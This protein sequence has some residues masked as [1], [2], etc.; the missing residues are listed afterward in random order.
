MNE[1]QIESEPAGTLLD[2]I[3]RAHKIVDL[4]V[5]IAP[6]LPCFADS[7]QHF[8][9]YRLHSYDEPPW[10]YVNWLLL[11]D[12]H[13]GTH[14]DAPPHFIPPLETGLPHAAPAG[15]VTLEQ[16]PLEAFLGPAAV[17]DCRDLLGTAGPD[18]S[19]VILPDKIKEWEAHHGGLQPGDVV[20]L[21][22]SWSDQYFK[23]FP[24][25]YRFNR[26]HPAPG[27]RTIEY[28]YSKGVR[29]LGLDTYGIGLLQDDAA[30][31][32]AS[33]GK[34]MV[35]TEK[36]CN[37][38]QLPARGAYFLFLPIKVEG[39]TGGPGRAIAIV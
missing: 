20:L 14:C 17:V 9:K 29:H 21:Y 7:G 26:S 22:T 23:R 39:V 24:E 19:P 3:I 16:M 8:V 35:V 12:D 13:T 11:M 31:H 2:K 34:G 25:G 33:L 1:P 6:D 28:L 27:P 4:T 10:P 5:T 32:W 36:L 37:L 15:S 38:G 18:E 30:P